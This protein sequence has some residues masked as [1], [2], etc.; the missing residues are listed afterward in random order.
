MSKAMS[1]CTPP[2]LTNAPGLAGL[3]LT[4]LGH[5]AR[6]GTSG[7]VVDLYTYIQYLLYHS[8]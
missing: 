6:L 1:L 2:P 5:V 4:T 3:D 8:L 7:K